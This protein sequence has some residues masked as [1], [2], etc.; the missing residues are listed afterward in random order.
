MLML[1]RKSRESVVIGDQ[2]RFD[3]LLKI[4][5]ME[6]GAGQVTLGFEVNENVPVRCEDAWERVLAGE[7]GK[8]ITDV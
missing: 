3:R 8:E 4:T 6:I 1:S 2:D 5:V 7:G